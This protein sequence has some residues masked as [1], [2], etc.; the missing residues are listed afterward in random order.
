MV[1]RGSRVPEVTGAYIHGDTCSGEVWAVNAT[2]PGAPVRVAS[3][4]RSLSSFALDA[5]GEALAIAFGR[6]VIR[7]TSP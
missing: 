7:L 4:L 2:N 6:P 5:D 3:G 1:Y